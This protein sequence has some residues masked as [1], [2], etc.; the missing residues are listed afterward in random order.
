MSKEELYQDVN[1]RIKWWQRSFETPT[2]RTSGNMLTVF[3]V[4]IMGITTWILAVFFDF[5]IEDNLLYLLIGLMVLAL[6]VG[7]FAT[8]E[9]VKEVAAIAAGNPH[10]SDNTNININNRKDGDGRIDN[11]DA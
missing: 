2:G 9:M 1:K 3:A 8:L 7:G 11:I 6:F 5:S 4:A 10:I